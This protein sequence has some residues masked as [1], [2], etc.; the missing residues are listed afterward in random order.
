[1]FQGY[2]KDEEATRETLQDGWVHTGDAGI[3]DRDGH[4]KIIDRV[5]DVGRLADGTLFAPTYL[6]NLI[7]FSPYIKEAV[8][9][10]REQPYVAVML[11]ID[12]QA[13]GNWAERRNLAY[14]GYTDL[15]QKA[16]VYDLVEQDLR[17]VNHTLGQDDA[18]R[19]ARVRKFLI[20]HKELDPDDEE[21]TRTRKVRRRFIN[22]KYKTL[23]DA[24]YSDAGHVPIE[25]KVTFEDGR[26]ALVR[27]NLAIRHL[28]GVA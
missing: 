6:E 9:V 25:A 3:L 23:I 4:L 16:E 10:G 20:L 15:A 13:V 5:K 21:I 7:K 2:F 19:G 12:T 27:A 17:R 11:N 1:M 8:A 26:S 22:E 18:L 24:L 14:T 28:D